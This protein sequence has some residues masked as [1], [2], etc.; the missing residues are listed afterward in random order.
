MAS[1]L[2]Y[3]RFRGGLKKLLSQICPKRPGKTCNCDKVLSGPKSEVKY[4]GEGIFFFLV[5]E[6]QVKKNRLNNNV[7]ET[8]NT[9][10]QVFT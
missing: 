2:V 4:D 5:E 6:A 9:E 1:K 10:R 7:L 8:S 3:M